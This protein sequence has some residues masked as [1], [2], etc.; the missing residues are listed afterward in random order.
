MSAFFKI[1]EF[2]GFLLDALFGPSA[3]FSLGISSH[4]QEIAKSIL[5]GIKSDV[6]KPLKSSIFNRNQAEEAFRYMTNGKYIGK[7]VFKIRDKE[8]QKVVEIKKLLVRAIPR[9]ILTKIEMK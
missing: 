7:V 9:T 2:G 3:N 4:K 8:S 5:N 1:I 6:V